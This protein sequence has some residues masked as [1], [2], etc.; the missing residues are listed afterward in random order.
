MRMEGKGVGGRR[1]ETDEPRLRRLIWFEKSTP[2]CPPITNKYEP[3]HVAV[4]DNRGITRASKSGLTSVQIKVSVRQQRNQHDRFPF[5]SCLR[6]NN[7]IHLNLVY[8]RH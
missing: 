4:C 1:K 5:S 7:L 3:I 2:S 6:V 8:E